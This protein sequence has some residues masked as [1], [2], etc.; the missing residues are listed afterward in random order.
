MGV[1]QRKIIVR[2]PDPSLALAWV[3][4]WVRQVRDNKI[5]PAGALD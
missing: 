2:N 3:P 1:G 5:R 4:E